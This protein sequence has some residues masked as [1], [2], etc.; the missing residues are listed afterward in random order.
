MTIEAELREKLAKIEA[1]FAGAGTA[2]ESGSP[3]RHA[4]SASA[5]AWPNFRS[6]IRGR[7]AILDARPV[8]A[9]PV[10]RALAGATGCRPI[11]IVGERRRP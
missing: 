11:A 1:L 4:W 10:R 5:R 7:N 8:V 3:R 9:A 6:A 2:L